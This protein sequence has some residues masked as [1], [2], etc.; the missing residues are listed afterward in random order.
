MDFGQ[1][2][3]FLLKTKCI[4]PILGTFKWNNTVEKEDYDEYLS[5]TTEIMGR[6]L[7]SIGS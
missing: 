4:F 1:K 3:H 6:S 7:S 2:C 5:E